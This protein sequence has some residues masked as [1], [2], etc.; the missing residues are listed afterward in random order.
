MAQPPG[1][2]TLASPSRATSGAITQKLAR[3]VE[4]SS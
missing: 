1:I 2:E 4:T 3:I